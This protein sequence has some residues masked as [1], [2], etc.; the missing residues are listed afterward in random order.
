MI[1]LCERVIQWF[2]VNYLA[3]NVGKSCFLIFSR[4][5]RACS[6]LN[7]IYVS[8]GSLNR[9]RDRCVR[10]LGILFDENLSFKP[11]IDLIKMKV[12][13][14][15]G[16]LK[17]LKHIFPG[18]ILRLLFYSLVQPYVSY[19]SIIW[20]STFPSSLKPLSKLYDKSRNLIQDTTVPYLNL[21]WT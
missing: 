4:V 12:S 9:P 13:R 10:F 18:S 1:P 19:C 20:M 15:L 21:C 5:S 2:D 7:E 6:G 8:R 17:K 14:S 3:L 16:I 11:H